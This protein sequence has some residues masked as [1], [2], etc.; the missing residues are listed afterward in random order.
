MTP[1]DNNP[2]PQQPEVDFDNFGASYRYHLRKEVADHGPAELAYRAAI[3]AAC[4]GLVYVSLQENSPSGMFMAGMVFLFIAHQVWEVL[5]E[6]AA[7]RTV[8]ARPWYGIGRTVHH[9]MLGACEVLDVDD[10]EE[11]A[12]IWVLIQP[13]ETEGAALWEM[14]CKVAETA[15]ELTTEEE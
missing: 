10:R 2:A 6:G 4:A 8:Q 11:V 15:A 7:R 5:I 14:A 13:L 9:R 3:S 12:H 1:H